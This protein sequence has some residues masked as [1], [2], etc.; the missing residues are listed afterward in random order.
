MLFLLGVLI[1]LLLILQAVA[2]L[3]LLERHLLGGSQ[4]RIG[5][6]K[7]GFNGILQAVFDG[8]KLMKKEQIVLSGS[9]FFM[10]LVVPVM[11]F[12]AMMTVWFTLYYFFEFLSFKYSG[13]FLLCVM[14][15]FVF[16]VL[17]SGVFS[18]SKY[19]FL[20]GLRSSVQSFSYEIAFSL[21]LLCLLFCWGGLMIFSGFFLV[22]YIM[23]FCVLFFVLVDLHRAPFD[24][25]E[26][27]SELVSGYNVEYSS[28]GFAI[29]FLGEY[30]NIIFFSCLLSCL[31]FSFS[32]GVVYLMLFFVIFSRSAYPR[33][34]FDK[35]MGVCWLSFLPLGIYLFGAYLFV[36]F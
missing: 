16:P 11:G 15:F 36:F 27:E 19:S 34:R 10:F 13:V 8:V 14:S 9:S 35:L 21:Y 2:F 7:V 3:T 25:S 22:F 31:F 18:S 26:C 5:P 32:F 20:G 28:V 1:M 33:F 24:F 4:C 23:F 17:L 6:N 12:L 30:G 29:L